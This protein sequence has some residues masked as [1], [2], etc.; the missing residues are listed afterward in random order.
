MQFYYY[1]IITK[2]CVLPGRILLIKI[3]E[4]AAL[5]MYEDASV[6]P[7]EDIIVGIKVGAVGSLVGS[8]LRRAINEK[9]FFVVTKAG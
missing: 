5:G 2:N 6:G 1:R 4:G 8:E 3:P 7:N 9:E